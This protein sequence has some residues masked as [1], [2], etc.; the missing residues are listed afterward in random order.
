MKKTYKEKIGITRDEFYDIINYEDDSLIY[1]DITGQGRW[2]VKHEVAFMR[3]GRP[4]ILFYTVGA[5]EQQYTE[6]PDYYDAFLAKPYTKT[7]YS[8]DYVE[9]E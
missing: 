3:D 5:T 7:F 4:W 1:D 8:V 9:A 2:D 6:D